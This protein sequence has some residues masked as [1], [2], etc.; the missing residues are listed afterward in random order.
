[1]AFPEIDVE[2]NLL[3]NDFKMRADLSHSGPSC[4]GQN[5]SEPILL[6]SLLTGAPSFSKRPHPLSKA[7]LPPCFVL[8][9]ADMFFDRE[10]EMVRKRCD[11]Y[12]NCEADGVYDIMTI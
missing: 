4:V 1:M 5:A 11:P 7:A 3:Q 10:G 2:E 12:S 6:V 9:H 8:S